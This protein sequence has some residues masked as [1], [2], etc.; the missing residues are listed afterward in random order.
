[1]NNSVTIYHSVLFFGSQESIFI[2][3]LYRKN[4]CNLSHIE[5]IMFELLTFTVL[6]N[7]FKKLIKR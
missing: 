7:M 6:D 4:I 1:M 5:E 3:H 2:L